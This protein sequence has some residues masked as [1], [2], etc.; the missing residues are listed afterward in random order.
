MFAVGIGII[1]YFAA[2][3]IELSPTWLMLIGA[4][5][6]MG[7]LV[8]GAERAVEEIAG[9]RKQEEDDK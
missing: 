5:L 3:G 6:G 7:V 1:I 2:S 8:A 4:M 9:R